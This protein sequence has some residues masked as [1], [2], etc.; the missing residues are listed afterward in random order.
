MLFRAE[1]PNNL[2]QILPPRVANTSVER[3]KGNR[4][5]SPGSRGFDVKVPTRHSEDEIYNT[6]YFPRDHRLMNNGV[7]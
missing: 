4:Y 7:N 1:D 3:I 2:H 6:N 5:P